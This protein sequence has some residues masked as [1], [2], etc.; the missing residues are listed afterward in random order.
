MKIVTI[1]LTFLLSAQLVYANATVCEN[2]A[3]CGQKLETSKSNMKDCPYHSSKKTNDTKEKKNSENK[4][5][6]KCCAVLTLET[7]FSTKPSLQSVL[8]FIVFQY[9]E[10]SL[11]A[12][13]SSFLRPPIS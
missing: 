9:K 10:S 12:M 7:T 3:N 1:L 11:I 2:L 13:S 6:C 4:V 8:S 5:Q